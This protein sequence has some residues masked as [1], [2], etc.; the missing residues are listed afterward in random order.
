[1]ENR[2]T[3]TGKGKTLKTTPAMTKKMLAMAYAPGESCETASQR[4]RRWMAGNP[5]LMRRLKKTGYR[6]AQKRLTDVQVKIILNFL[7]TP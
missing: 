2:H 5:N 4:L 1:M 6:Q 3:M 7:G